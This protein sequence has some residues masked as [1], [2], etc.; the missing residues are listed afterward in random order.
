MV[1]EYGPEETSSRERAPEEL[2][3]EAP[4]TPTRSE[5][6]EEELRREAA[7]QATALP[8][9]E[10]PSLPKTE[11]GFV[12][13]I[14]RQGWRRLHYLGGCSRIPGIHYLNFNFLGEAVPGTE[15]YDDVCK[16]CWGPKGAG[17]KLQP[18]EEGVEDLPSPETSEA[19]GA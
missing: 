7:A 11:Q 9:E 4:P 3:G 19:E 1:A 17:P 5:A 10:E 13:S 6:A 8:V 14:S 12:T 15:D 16:Q 2:A 18:E